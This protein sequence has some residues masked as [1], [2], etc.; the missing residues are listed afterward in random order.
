MAVA[1]ALAG[2]S[3]AIPVRP[4]AALDGP[5]IEYS[6][7]RP[8]TVSDAAV[9]SP[10]PAQHSVFLPD[11]FLCDS[12]PDCRIRVV[13][14]VYPANADPDVT[15]I[16]TVT[17]TIQGAGNYELEVF[18]DPQ[19]NS[20]LVAADTSGQRELHANIVT[21]KD[22]PVQEFG[23]AMFLAGGTPSPYRLSF[24][25]VIRTTPAPFESLNP[26]G[27]PSLTPG[28][29]SAP[30]ASPGGP[31]G[32]VGTRSPGA[33]AGPG[34][35][36]AAPA[37]D[38]QPGGLDILPVR[39]DPAFGGSFGN[40]SDFQSA[41][42]PGKVDLFKKAAAVRPP[43]NPDPLQL[44]LALL[45]FPAALMILFVVLVRRRRLQDSLI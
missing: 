15:Y 21:G 30:S 39:T 45:A 9:G 34:G 19:T 12:G 33:P 44:A 6:V 18:K 41:L 42:A 14:I 40:G 38:S 32:T 36:P 5:D 1:V 16:T 43:G 4:A 25:S 29:P 7:D 10:D 3:I 11:A 37:R 31:P 28:S 8:L 23:V 22:D 13:D 27:G 24:T 2:L 20:V 26:V 35:G 17:A